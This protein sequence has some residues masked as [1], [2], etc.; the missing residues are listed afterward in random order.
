MDVEDV[1]IVGGGPAGLGAALVLGRMRRRVLMVDAGHPRNAPAA[2][3]HGFLT[4]DGTPPGDLLA[5]GREEVRA[6]GVRIE[7]GS[8]VEVER[9]DGGFRVVHDAGPAVLARTLL[10]ATG[11]TDEL[12]EIDGMRDR[13]GRDVLHC[14]YCHGYEV[15]DRPVGVIAAS[16]LSVHQ[17]L[18]VRQLSDDVVLFR[19]T[20]GDLGEDAQRLAARGITVVD[21]EVAGLAV[22]DDRLVGVRLASGRVVEREAVF[23]APFF[24]A[25][26]TVLTALGVELQETPQFVTAVTDADGATSVPGV[27]A[28]GN[29][30]DARAQIVTSAAAGARAAQA[31]NTHLLEADVERALGE[32]AFS[33]RREAELCEQIAGARR[34]GL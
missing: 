30:S 27:W 9:V 6:V 23:V 2:H 17:A 5:F 19:H 21:G 22:R 1:V 8:V 11:L 29:V 34:H 4:R 28:A 32:D 3:A 25:Q 31:I 18:L 14:P 20:V 16:R 15:R 12:P 10:V 24:R 7:V 13:W 26:S 33:P